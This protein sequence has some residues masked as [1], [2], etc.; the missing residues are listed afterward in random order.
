MF[1]KITLLVKI[2]G[3]GD[4][5]LI[6]S[7]NPLYFCNTL[8]NRTSCVDMSPVFKVRWKLLM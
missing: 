6:D 4:L 7:F 1:T 8:D 3:V 5:S 2:G